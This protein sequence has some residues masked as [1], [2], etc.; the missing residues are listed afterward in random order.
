MRVTGYIRQIN[1]TPADNKVR[2]TAVTLGVV[3]ASGALIV[4][5]EMVVAAVA[6]SGRWEAI[7]DV[8]T[9]SIEVKGKNGATAK[10]LISITEETADTV[11]FEELLVD[12][13]PHMAEP[14]GGARP[15]A[16]PTIAGLVK[17]DEPAPS[18]ADAIAVT[19]FFFALTR[20]DLTGKANLAS[21]KFA[22]VF[23]TSQFFGWSAASLAAAD[24]ETVLI[25]DDT[26]G[27]EPGRWV[28]MAVAGGGGGGSGT[29]IVA[30]LA[31]MKALTS[32]ASLQ[33]VILK[34]PDPGVGKQYYFAF[35][36]TTAEDPDNPYEVVAPNDAGGR[37]FFLA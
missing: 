5:D 30:D 12:A 29:R 13:A 27:D 28:E 18:G 20:E 23:G 16:S 4:P 8:G 10:R 1:T 26:A 22:V 33:L 9:Y 34:T 2:I 31:A 25:P 19:G 36:D 15:Q 14:A 11:P 7:L 35:G 3:T 24:G 17:L 6:A 21:N 37:F 32:S